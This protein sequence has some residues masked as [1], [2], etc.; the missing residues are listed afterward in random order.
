MDSSPDGEQTACLFHRDTSWDIPSL[1]SELEAAASGWTAA[2][3]WLARLRPGLRT[4]TRAN[5]ADIG[6]HD[7]AHRNRRS[8][9]STA[10]VRRDPFSFIL[11]DL[12]PL[13]TQGLAAFL[14]LR[15]TRGQKAA[16]GQCPFPGANRAPLPDT[17]DALLRFISRERL[18]SK[19]Q[20]H[21]ACHSS[22]TF[23]GVRY[24]VSHSKNV[25]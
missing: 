10:T 1:S 4:A 7:G 23:R 13:E 9:R 14:T 5:P 8:E 17:G 18:L 2:P 25:H 6:R 16:D 20:Q 3:T 24:S 22:G 19:P 12:L 11:G 21:R 15:S